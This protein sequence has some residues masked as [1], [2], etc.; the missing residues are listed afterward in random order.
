M[1]TV[2]GVEKGVWAC[3]VLLDNGDHINYLCTYD[4]YGP[5]RNVFDAGRYITWGSGRG[6]GPGKK[7]LIVFWLL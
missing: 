4:L 7:K 2:C 1:Y 5:V 6:F 3:G